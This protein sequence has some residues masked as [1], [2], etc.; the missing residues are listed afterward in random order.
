MTIVEFL[1]TSLPIL[2]YTFGI[3]L[4]IILIIIGIKF[5]KTIDKVENI[6]SDVDSKVKSLNKLFK[7]I[8]ITTDKLSI[9]T[10]KTVDF[11]A[12][13]GKSI[14]KNK[15]KEKKNEKEEK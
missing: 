10:D 11:I 3:V 8:D 12:N 5:I 4:L 2:L 14:F 9:F 1:N 15:K 13:I 7:V 6:V